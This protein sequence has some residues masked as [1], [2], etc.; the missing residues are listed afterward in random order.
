MPITICCMNCE[1]YFVDT[2]NGY[3]TIDNTIIDVDLS[4]MKRCK[5]Y[6]MWWGAVG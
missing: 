5:A 1:Y 2:E 6:K 3:C 4:Y